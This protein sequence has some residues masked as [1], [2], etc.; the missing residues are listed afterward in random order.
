MTTQPSHKTNV[1]I[2]RLL[3]HVSVFRRRQ[4]R[5]A[6]VKVGNDSVPVIPA[7]VFRGPLQLKQA[8]AM[9]KCVCDD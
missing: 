9:V 4:T 5:L 7:A 2:R 8:A 1:I 6:G 3:L